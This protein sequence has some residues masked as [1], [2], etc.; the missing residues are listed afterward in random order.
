MTKLK[1]TYVLRGSATNERWKSPGLRGKNN[2]NTEVL[3]DVAPS[4]YLERHLI[5]ETSI[6]SKGGGRTGIQIKI[7]VGD[8]PRILRHMIKY[9]LEVRL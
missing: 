4:S 2:G 7:G 9:E 3:L 1:D 5:L 6:R 8:F